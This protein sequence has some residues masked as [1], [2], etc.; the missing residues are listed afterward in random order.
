[1]MLTVRTWP[2]YITAQPEQFELPLAP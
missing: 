1:M 2:T